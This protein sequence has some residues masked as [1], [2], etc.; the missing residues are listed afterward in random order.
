LRLAICWNFKRRS[1]KFGGGPLR[2]SAISS[3]WGDI[4]DSIGMPEITFHCLRHTHVSQLIAE[5]V[6]IVTLSKRLGHAKPNVTL[7]IY[8]HMFKSDDGKAAAAINAA[9]NSPNRSS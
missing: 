7:A 3:D 9:L 6:D 1:A 5:G 2:P 4:A 8:A